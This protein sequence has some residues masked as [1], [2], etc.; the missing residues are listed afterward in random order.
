MCTYVHALLLSNS[1]EFAPGLPSLARHR[2]RLFLQSVPD[3]LPATGLLIAGTSPTQSGDI[4]QLPVC[5][6]G[7]RGWDVGPPSF[8]ARKGGWPLGRRH[9]VNQRALCLIY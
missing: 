8:P 1:F 3:P 2:G 7:F 4:S 5:I 6:S 9:P